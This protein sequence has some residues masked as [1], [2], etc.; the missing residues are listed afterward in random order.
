[1]TYLEPSMIS[2]FHLDSHKN[3]IAF[4]F[5]VVDVIYL[6][7]VERGCSQWAL[8][9]RVVVHSSINGVMRFACKM[10]GIELSNGRHGEV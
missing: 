1:M 9:K 10:D 8:C 3:G 6:L 2:P 4:A 7:L 5:V